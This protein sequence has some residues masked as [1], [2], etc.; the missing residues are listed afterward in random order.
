M[1][2]KKEPPNKLITWTIE[3]AI[4]SPRMS[5]SLRQSWP[6]APY[7]E[8][9]VALPYA[10]RALVLFLS[11]AT[12]TMLICGAPA[13]LRQIALLACLFALPYLVLMAGGVPAPSSVAP[14]QFAR[15]QVNALPVIS[16]VPL[17]L[18]FIVLR[19]PAGCRS[20]HRDASLLPDRPLDR[21]PLILILALLALFMAGYPFIGLVPNEQ[22]RNAYESL[23]QAA[24]IAYV[25][26]LTLYVRLRD[27]KQNPS[28]M[29]K[30]P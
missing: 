25:F 13:S 26:G 4:L 5:L 11:L 27:F 22:K 15:Y 18:A 24:M 23:V 8:M 17:L 14:A 1:D 21:L 2:V 10:G 28:P 3:R 6:Y 30:Y 9:I 20:W 16:I 7:Q 29:V 12:L 19:E